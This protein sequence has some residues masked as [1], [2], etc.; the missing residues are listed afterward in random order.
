MSRG[1]AVALTAAAGLLIALQAPINSRLGKGVGTFPAA[2]VSFATGL[3]L[4][5]GISLI[6]AGGLGSLGQ[7]P[8]Q[9]W[10]TLFGGVL[11]A[12][13]IATVLV[14]VRSLGAA[15]VIAATIAGQ[16]TAAVLI[17]H[18]GLLGVARHPFGAARGAGLVLL[19]GGVL[20]IVRR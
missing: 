12:G 17:D 18:F 5:L 10:W 13:Y 20:L 2:V 16:L 8:R 14:T 15:G 3:I 9:P 11:G 1:L 6:A 4:L 19:A 7:L